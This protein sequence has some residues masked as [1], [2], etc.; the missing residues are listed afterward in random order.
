MR[1]L[2]IYIH[3][4]ETLEI[5]NK[6]LIKIR[7]EHFKKAGSTHSDAPI[8][9]LMICTY[10]RKEYLLDNKNK[11]PETIV[12]STIE[13]NKN[14]FIHGAISYQVKSLNSHF[15]SESKKATNLLSCNSVDKNLQIYLRLKKMALKV[16]QNT[17]VTESLFK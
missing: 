9:T 2:K 1:K 6:R 8:E 10:C 4:R 5:A 16:S 3:G 14:L 11:D 13:F 7:A 17:P 12:P 15:E